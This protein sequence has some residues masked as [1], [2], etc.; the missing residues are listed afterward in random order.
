MSPTQRSLKELRNA[1]FTVD[2]CE[3]WVPGANIRRDLFNIADLLA[4]KKGEK[5]LLIQVTSSGVAQRVT[6]IRA[7]R[8]LEM[9]MSVFDIEVHGWTKRANGRY[10]QRIVSIR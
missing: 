2:I 6:K 3:R 1:G 5:P 9:L 8:Q 10:K 4:V 7:H